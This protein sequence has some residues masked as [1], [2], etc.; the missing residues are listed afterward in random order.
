MRTKQITR[1]FLF[2]ASDLLSPDSNSFPLGAQVVSGQWVAHVVFHAP[3]HV[4]VLHAAER[5]RFLYRQPTGPNPL[6]HRDDLSGSAL[7]HG[8]LNSLFR[9]A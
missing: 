5:G 1:R 6:N 9:V 8:I 3:S 4:R 2:S 7:R